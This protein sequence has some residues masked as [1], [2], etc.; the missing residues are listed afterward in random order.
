MIAILPGTVFT[1]RVAWTTSPTSSRSRPMEFPLDHPWRDNSHL[2]ACPPPFQI[3]LDGFFPFTST[4]EAS[5]EHGYSRTD[6]TVRGYVVPLPQLLIATP[7]PMLFPSLATGE[8]VKSLLYT[9]E[10]LGHPGGGGR[11][12]AA[13]QTFAAATSGSSD[14]VVVL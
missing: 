5:A 14:F 2:S 9:G 1:S 6:P 13:E 12:H 7:R 11:F 8:R 3:S 10:A 4:S